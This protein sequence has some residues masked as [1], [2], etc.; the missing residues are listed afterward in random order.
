ML[1]R[2]GHGRR[3]FVGRSM[4]GRAHRLLDYRPQHSDSAAKIDH[5]TVDVTRRPAGV[6]S[7]QRRCPRPRRI[8]WIAQAVAGSTGRDSWLPFHAPDRSDNI[9]VAG[10]YGEL[11]ATLLERMREL[12][13]QCVLQRETTMRSAREIGS[14]S[15]AGAS[16]IRQVSGG[17]GDCACSVESDSRHQ[18]INER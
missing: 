8:R 12:S 4:T 16:A 14:F 17:N 5:E 7:N 2:S 15:A 10:P 9:D 3:Y 11:R 6:R 1:Q 18:M 13:K